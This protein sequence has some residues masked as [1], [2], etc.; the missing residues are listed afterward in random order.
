MPSGDLEAGATDVRPA[1]KR[2][3]I[4][5]AGPA[6]VGA[7]IM[8][9]RSGKAGVTVLERADRVGGNSG[10]FTLEGVRCDYG[11][12]RLHP[13][14]DPQIL[15][16][17]KDVVGSDLLWRPRHGRILLKGRWI[18]FPL[19]PVD[20]ALR[21]PKPFAAA[22]M[23]DA[24]TKSLRKTAAPETFASVLH[25][26]LGPA[27]CEGFYYPYMTKLWALDPKDLAVTLARRRISGSSVGKIIK[28]VLA[29]I[30]GL[31]KP[32]TG[33]FY[34][35]RQGFGQICDALKTGAEAA[36]ATFHL[37]SAVT[38]IEHENG[39]VVAVSHDHDGSHERIAA[40][41]VWS[42]LPITSLA[43]MMS[44]APPAAVL[45]ACAAIRYRGMIL[46]YLVLEQSQFT[47]YDAHYFPELAVPISRL[48]EPKNYSA[49][50]DP[51]GLTVLCAELPC[52][53]GEPLWALDDDALGAK[54]CTWLAAAGLP[55]TAR[56]KR[57]VTRRLGYAYPVYD[58]SFES[59]LAVVDDWIGGIDGLLT[60]GRQGLFAH[61]NTHHAMAM[62]EGAVDCLH[63]DGSFDRAKWA[64]YR[65]A[66]EHHV[67]ED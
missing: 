56:V 25:K 58:R 35:P 57:T 52:D 18:H 30:P 46:I 36:G 34:Y 43:Q 16:L 3:L 66:F 6:G 20:L 32:T 61:D 49:T 63:A 14:S 62:A 53:P 29:Q 22:L 17:I 12:H 38:K 26:G 37:G 54:L 39:K 5:G 51:E 27:M 40:D 1:A 7:A 13:A 31:K 2:A 9:A 28:K 48:S 44:P 4:L 41:I 24:A 55:V 47:E 60:F 65:A 15:Q 67:V 10:S 64:D 42:T 23:Y 8:L 50:T 19:K 45:E 21:L 11:S 33:G 59:N